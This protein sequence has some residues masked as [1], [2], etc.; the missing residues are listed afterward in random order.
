M[1]DFLYI[2]QNSCPL[3]PLSV[4]CPQPDVVKRNEYLYF[5][6]NL[7]IFPD[8]LKRQWTISFSH[9]VDDEIKANKNEGT[10]LSNIWYLEG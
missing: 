2:F 1:S 3:F 5:L 7:H 4:P 8:T 10:R 6:I 9:F